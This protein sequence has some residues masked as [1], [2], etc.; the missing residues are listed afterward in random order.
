MSRK[1]NDLLDTDEGIFSLKVLDPAMGSGHFLV[2]ATDYLARALVEA[3]GGKP[4]EMEEEEIRWARREV[5]ERCVYGVDFNPLAVELAKLSL[6]LHTVSRDKPLNFL[7][8]HLR[9]GNSL[10]GA[11]VR[12]LGILPELGKKGKAPVAGTTLAGHRFSSAAAAAVNSFYQ[13]M[14]AP[15]ETIEDIHRKESAYETARYALQRIKEI[16]DVWTSVYFGN[17]VKDKVS[18]E[19]LLQ[20]AESG[21]GDWP[22]KA[23]VPWLG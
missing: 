20:L 17:E 6:W 18:Y 5:V 11:W 3:L 13:I 1:G 2:E 10:I 7:D 8:H 16:A 21:E 19:N 4:Q 14:E 23:K 22:T 12:D 15:S 9:C